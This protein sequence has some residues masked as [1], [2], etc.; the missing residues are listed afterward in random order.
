MVSLEVA[1]DRDYDVSYRNNNNYYYYNTEDH[2]Y[3]A[4]SY[5]T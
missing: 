3:S 5:G 1:L 2:I 4:I